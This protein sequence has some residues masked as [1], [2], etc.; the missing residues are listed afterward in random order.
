MGFS[1]NTLVISVGSEHCLCS[2]SSSSSSSSYSL[3]GSEDQH[4]G[5]S[6]RL[7]PTRR[8]PI[9]SASPRPISRS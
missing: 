6:R 5:P 3:M 4:R 9:P 8:V 2:S 1:E 7:C